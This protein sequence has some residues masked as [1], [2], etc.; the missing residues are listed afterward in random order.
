MKNILLLTL[1]AIGSLGL[2]QQTPQE[3]MLALKKQIVGEYT[4][5]DS[6]VVHTENLETGDTSENT[7]TDEYEVKLTVQGKTAVYE[8]DGFTYK[9]EL[10]LK[11]GEVIV[12]SIVVDDDKYVIDFEHQ[13]EGCNILTSGTFLLCHKSSVTSTWRKRKSDYEVFAKFVKK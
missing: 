5:R 6:V 13:V 10:A 12:S 1:L 3:K 2:A 8:Y 9:L 11:N 7:D 4:V